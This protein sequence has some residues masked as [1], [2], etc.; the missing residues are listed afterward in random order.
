LVLT[1]AKLGFTNIFSILSN[2]L[3]ELIVI[4]NEYDNMII[5]ISLINPPV[6]PVVFI[7]PK[8][9]KNINTIEIIFK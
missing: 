6:I 5:I 7:G 4:Y 2:E 8:R 1:L 3:D 9:K